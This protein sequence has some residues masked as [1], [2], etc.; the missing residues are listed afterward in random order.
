M[1]C[2]R[3]GAV[4]IA[5][6]AVANVHAESARDTVPGRT[7]S[8]N[9]PFGFRV[10]GTAPT[11][12]KGFPDLTPVLGLLPVD[13]R[14]RPTLVGLSTMTVT[15]DN[16]FSFTSNVDSHGKVIGQF[17]GILRGDGHFSVQIANFD[18]IGILKVSTQ[19][20][21]LFQTPPIPIQLSF[22]DAQANSTVLLN[23]PDLTITY[24]VK[25]GTA[26]ATAAR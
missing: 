23:K 24:K 8:T 16:S 6:F 3:I 15:F 9:Q 13:Q 22:T 21:G 17:K 20:D 5:L 4:L 12:V 10:K 14:K 19:T 25:H 18:V 26:V 1:D 7:D 11:L 2:R